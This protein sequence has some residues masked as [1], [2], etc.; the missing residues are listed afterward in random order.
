MLTWE[1]LCEDRILQDLPYKIETNRLNQI[2][3]SPASNWHGGLQH[4]IGRKLAE[5]MFGGRVIT[6]CAVQTTD[7]VKVP[8]VAWVSEERLAPHKRSAS[9]PIAPE[10]CVEILSYSN[11]MFEMSGKMQ[12]YFARGAAEVWLCD[13]EGN[14][15]FYRHDHQGATVSKLCPDFP[16]KFEW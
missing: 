11:S 15:T 13:E 7:G 4:E 12:L 9:M 14:V 16:V 5:M 10:I 8:D 6:E 1:E 3:M 2:I